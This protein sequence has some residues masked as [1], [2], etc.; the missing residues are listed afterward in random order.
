MSTRT[1][2]PTDPKAKRYEDLRKQME[3]KPAD[4]PAMNVPTLTEEVKDDDQ[5]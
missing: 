1:L 4:A 2:E 5:R 3:Q